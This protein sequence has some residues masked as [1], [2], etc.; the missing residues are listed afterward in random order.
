MLIH[1]LMFS[2]FSKFLY[3]SHSLSSILPWLKIDLAFVVACVIA[4]CPSDLDLWCCCSRATS[5][6]SLNFMHYC[7]YLH[8][9]ESKK[10]NLNILIK[11]ND[12]LFNLA[13]PVIIRLAQR[14]GAI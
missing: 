11:P 6:N 9:I 12:L 3:H 4:F 5:N 13:L 14:H 10:W 8:A 7:L 2:L 1:I